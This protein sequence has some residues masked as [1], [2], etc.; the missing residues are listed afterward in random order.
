MKLIR[1]SLL[2]PSAFTPRDIHQSTLA[3]INESPPQTAPDAPQKRAPI[4]VSQK[5]NH[6]VYR[7]RGQK[8]HYELPTV[9]QHAGD[10]FGNTSMDMVPVCNRDKKMWQRLRMIRRNG[11]APQSAC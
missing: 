9:H 5:T 4:V 1:P 7:E 11:T 8:R 2:T 6:V 3:I 10:L